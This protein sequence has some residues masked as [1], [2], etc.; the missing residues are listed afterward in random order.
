MK[1]RTILILNRQHPT[2]WPSRVSGTDGD[3]PQ[4]PGGRV[5]HIPIAHRINRE[6]V[7]GVNPT[8]RG[9]TDVDSPWPAGRSKLPH[10]PR[11]DL[12]STT[13]GP[14]KGICGEG[15][16]VAPSSPVKTPQVLAGHNGLRG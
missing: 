6:T 3:F 4:V 5:P 8:R 14:I 12:N 1:K 15:I 2:S 7:H 9:R 16:I 10:G 13:A 11:I